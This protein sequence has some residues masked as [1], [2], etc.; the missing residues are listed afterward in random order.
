MAFWQANAKKGPVINISCT[1]YINRL[2]YSAATLNDAM[3][4][5]ERLLYERPEIVLQSDDVD[6]EIEIA[7]IACVFRTGSGEFIGWIM[8]KISTDHR[9]RF[10][11]CN[12]HLYGSDYLNGIVCGCPESIFPNALLQRRE[13]VELVEKLSVGETSPDYD[14]KPM[15][16]VMR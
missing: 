15:L 5:I 7:H 9:Q 1:G 6:K 10:V 12:K 3:D 8:S 13:V 14:L 2:P 4:S 16:E 11:Y